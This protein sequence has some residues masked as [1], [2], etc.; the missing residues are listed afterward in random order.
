M[1]DQAE[2]PAERA[3]RLATRMQAA[4]ISDEVSNAKIAELGGDVLAAA[5]YFENLLNQRDAEKQDRESAFAAFG[6]KPPEVAAVAEETS[7]INYIRD[8]N[9][10]D[11]DIEIERK[12]DGDTPSEKRKELEA[13]RDGLVR[14]LESMV[15]TEKEKER[16]LDASLRLFTRLQ[17]QKE[18]VLDSLKAFKGLTPNRNELMNQLNSFVDKIE[19]LRKEGDVGTPERREAELKAAALE[20]EL[21][22]AREEVLAAIENYNP[23]GPLWLAVLREFEL[24]E[25]QKISRENTQ[26]R[27]LLEILDVPNLRIRYGEDVYKYQEK[28]NALARIHNFAVAGNGKGAVEITAALGELDQAALVELFQ[29]EELRKDIVDAYIRDRIVFDDLNLAGMA[30]K[31]AEARLEEETVLGNNKRTFKREV[32]VDPN[33][34]TKVTYT[35][36][37]ETLYR[38]TSS[39]AEK[40]ALIAANQTRLTEGYKLKK[41][42]ETKYV[43]DVLADEFFSTDMI[44]SFRT[45]EGVAPTVTEAEVKKMI[46]ASYKYNSRKIILAQE[47]DNMIGFL[48]TTV[49]PMVVEPIRVKTTETLKNKRTEGYIFAGK[50]KDNILVKTRYPQDVLEAGG[51]INSRVLDI[52]SPIFDKG[53]YKYCDPESNMYSDPGYKLMMETFGMEKPTDP[54]KA[55][56]VIDWLE[57]F[58]TVDALR[59]I[60]NNPEVVNKL[61]DDVYKDAATAQASEMYDKFEAFQKEPNEESAKAL[62]ASYFSKT[63][64]D[65]RNF[66]MQV[67]EALLNYKR[68][69]N[70]IYAFEDFSE[71]KNW[72]ARRIEDYI[73]KAREAGL[74]GLREENE[75][76]RRVFKGKEVRLGKL[77][78]ATIPTL[79]KKAEMVSAWTKEVFGPKNLKDTAFSWVKTLFK[80]SADQIKSDLK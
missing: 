31:Q 43:D 22:K 77:K 53:F 17:V 67:I 47:M 41:A 4:G 34:P 44:A 72:G 3:N 8:L 33:D 62:M 78:I 38:T 69:I 13:K 18:A 39:D 48:E 40:K 11:I 54:V 70:N 58:K 6:A 76:K 45:T 10:T 36:E 5:N 60:R 68:K 56:D 27:R 29:A 80:V 35:D 61:K 59:Q 74:I 19:G 32:L 25:D 30:Q 63:P 71:R 14:E 52:T 23:I 21:R 64:E 75:L 7:H 49:A 46:E 28:F 16:Y 42:W 79:G 20:F 15:T 24:A 12:N 2:N 73:R 1:T 9:S 65:R 51:K 50:Y 26:I 37:L 66:N 57:R 55:N